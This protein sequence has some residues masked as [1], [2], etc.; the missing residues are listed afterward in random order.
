M[1]RRSPVKVN[2]QLVALLLAIVLF[3]TCPIP[4]SFVLYHHLWVP[5]HRI[6]SPSPGPLP[7]G[8]FPGEYILGSITFIQLHMPKALVWLSVFL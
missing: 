5:I 7:R 4:T 2:I 8:P 1:D 6:A 3:P